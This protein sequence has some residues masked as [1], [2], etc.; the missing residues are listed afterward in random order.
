MTFS[1]TYFGSSSWLVEIDNFRILIDPWFKGDLVFLPGP[2]L[3]KGTLKSNFQVPK[4]INLILLTQGLPDHSHPE[5]LDLFNR[6]IPIIGSAGAVKVVYKLGFRNISKLLPG[7]SLK[8]DHITIEATAGA[9]VPNPENGYIVSNKNFSFYVE[10]H[11]F[12]D[13]HIKPRH[14]DVIFTP[15]VDLSIPLAGSFIE[16]KS[17]LPKLL[18]TF[19]PHTIFASTTG[20]DATFTGIL[21]NL[22]SVNGTYE[23]ASKVINGDSIFINPVLDKLYEIKI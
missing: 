1:A 4:K 19:T 10:P 2:W 3:I 12:L 21:N 5:S 7:Q 17:I 16:G 11:G 9:N 15:V 20:G 13:Q 22:I 6:S 14:V 23:E 18:K 8:I